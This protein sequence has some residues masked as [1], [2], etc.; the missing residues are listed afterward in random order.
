MTYATSYLTDIY[1]FSY[2]P[3]MIMPYIY[4]LIQRNAFGRDDNNAIIRIS[5]GL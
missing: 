4:S 5:E 3:K 1:P 2:V